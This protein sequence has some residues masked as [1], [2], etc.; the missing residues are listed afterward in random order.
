MSRKI[1]FYITSWAPAGARIE[2]LRKELVDQGVQD[3]DV[4]IISDR[5][6]RPRS[7][8]KAI[9]E[10]RT[11]Y[12]GF[13]ED[14]IFPSSDAVGVLCDLLD[15]RN[16]IG[17]AI[18]PVMQCKAEK[19][20]R[21]VPAPDEGEAKA[22]QDQSNRMW[23]LNFVLF[24]K[25]TNVLFDA[26]YFGNQMFDWD[27]GLELL[28]AGYLSV[29]D[30][31]AAVA[32]YQTDYELKNVCYHACVARNRQIFMS[33]WKD[34]ENWRGLADFNSRNGHS[35]P[36]MEELTHANEKFL[37]DYIAKYDQYGLVE[38]YYKSRFGSLPRLNEFTRNF[39]SSYLNKRTQSFDPA[40][41]T[42]HSF[43]TFS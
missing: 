39:E 38:C 41:E 35:V 29:A 1:T 17:L 28:R 6:S 31:R 25:S 15:R 16:D 13:C 19:L 10:C 7:L 30:R 8:N 14:D 4:K 36:S 27:F 32:H 40:L 5:T 21:P 42:E 22:L 2:F 23:T 20:V 24:R 37:F 26:D 34:R 3:D 11:P 18:A 43:P 12:V 9:E 33:K